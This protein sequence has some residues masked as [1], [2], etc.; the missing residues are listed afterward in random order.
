MPIG[1]INDNKGVL[2]VNMGHLWEHADQLVGWLRE[3]LVLIEDGTIRPLVHA[4]FPFEK[5]GE[6]HQL[7]H[8]RKN[9]GKVILVP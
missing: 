5:A 1:L 4:T 9:V 2:G 3:I 8:D 6:A 7:I